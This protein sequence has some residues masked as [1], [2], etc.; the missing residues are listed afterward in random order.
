MLAERGVPVILRDYFKERFSIDEL[1]ALLARLDLTPRDILS[2]R[3]RAYATLIGDREAR[4]SDDDLLALIVQEPTLVR[5]PLTVRAGQA[6][7][8]FDRAGIEQLVQ[9]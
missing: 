7:I 9:S 1:R 5:R 4:L 3:A 8:G 2:R 6:V